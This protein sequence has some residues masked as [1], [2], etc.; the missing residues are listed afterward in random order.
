MNEYILSLIIGIFFGASLEL[1]G[2]GSP[3]KL[4]NQF[5]LTDFTMFKV[6]FGA[7]FVAASLYAVADFLNFSSVPNSEI[8]SLDYGLLWGGLILGAGLVLGGYCPGTA[9]AGAAGGRLDAFVFLFMMFF[10]Y[11]FYS[12]SALKFETEMLASPLLAPH[13]TLPE[14]LSVPIWTVLIGLFVILIIGWMLGSVIEK[15]SANQVNN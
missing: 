13:S 14:L 5:L 8:S 9:L 12:W 10:G 7:I 15:K 2:F 1:A 6:M 3:K 11:R 4:N